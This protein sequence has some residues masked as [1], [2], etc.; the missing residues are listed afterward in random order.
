L[1]QFISLP[2]TVGKDGS[3]SVGYHNCP[4]YLNNTEFVQLAQT[5]WIGA[6][7]QSA[8]LMKGSLKPIGKAEERPCSP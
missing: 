3:L 1:S 7:S 4:R 2:A 6:G 8:A 5:G